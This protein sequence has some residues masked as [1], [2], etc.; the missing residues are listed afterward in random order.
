VTTAGAAGDGSDLRIPIGISAHHVHLCRGHVE[1]LFGIGHQ[2]TPLKQLDQPGQFACRECVDLMGPRGQVKNVR[3]LGPER[4]RTQVEI[5]RTEEFALG[6]DAPIRNSGDLDG[7]PGL[8]LVG[9]SGRV[10][11]SE[12]VICAK[13]HIHMTPADARHFGV[14]P[15][16]HVLVK[17]SGQ[18]REL[19]FGD[20]V[21]RVSHDYVL[22]MHLDTDEANAGELFSDSWGQLVRLAK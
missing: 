3:I 15:G 16:E 12:G 22:E 5:S 21:V 7:S 8:T 4:R 20:V 19:I 6:I 13:R 10:E 2:L 14:D 17:A 1:K 18:G 11:I 9:S